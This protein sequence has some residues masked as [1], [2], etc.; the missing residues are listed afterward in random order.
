[1]HQN[2]LRSHDFWFVAR[3]GSVTCAT[4]N[5]RILP[6]ALSVKIRQLDALRGPP[7]CRRVSGYLLLT[8]A[9][10][11]ALGSRDGR[12]KLPFRMLRSR[13]PSKADHGRPPA[14]MRVSDGTARTR[15]TVQPRASASI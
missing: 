6:S 7:L 11:F 10:R 8:E 14:S 3:K 4:E 12:P 9:S 2:R 5:L 15:R 13:A 1:M